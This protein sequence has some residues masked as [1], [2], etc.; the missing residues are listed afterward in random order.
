[1]LAPIKSRFFF[2]PHLPFTFVFKPK[3][4]KSLNLPPRSVIRAI[5]KLERFGLVRREGANFGRSRKAIDI[6]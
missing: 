6:E 4:A 2:N 1:M 5:E 3:L